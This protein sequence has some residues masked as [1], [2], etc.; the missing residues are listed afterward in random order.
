[1][2]NEYTLPVHAVSARRDGAGIRAGPEFAMRFLN[3]GAHVLGQARIEIEQRLVEQKCLGFAHD[4]PAHGDKP[5][6]SAREHAGLALEQCAE[7]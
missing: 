2:G 5:E 7:P 1:M 3:F 4:R 6:L